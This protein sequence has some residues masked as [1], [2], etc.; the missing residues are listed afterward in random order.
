MYNEHGSFALLK[1][2]VILI[3]PSSDG[4]EISPIQDVAAWHLASELYFKLVS[5]L[6][7]NRDP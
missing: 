4:P 7:R 3:H 1:E 5:V 6:F 2:D